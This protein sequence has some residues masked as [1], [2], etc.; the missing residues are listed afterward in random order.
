MDRKDRFMQRN[1]KEAGARRGGKDTAFGPKFAEFRK[2]A[3]WKMNEEQYAGYTESENEFSGLIG[4]QRKD[5]SG[6]RGKN[7]K[8]LSGLNSQVSQMSNAMKGVKGTSLDNEYNKFKKGFMEVGIYDGNNRE[9]KHYLPREVVEN[10]N[11]GINKGYHGNFMPN[12][13]YN[14]DVQ[15]RGGGGKR[16]KELRQAIVDAERD[17]KV[18]FWETNGRAVGQANSQVNKAKGDYNTAMGQAANARTNISNSGKV[19]DAQAREVDQ[20]VKS[21]DTKRKQIATDYST[22]LQ[23]RRNLHKRN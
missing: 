3:G 15:T 8:A 2:D 13:A 14:I 22:A 12:G 17:V 5:I 6:A 4:K 1:R 23:G 11:E 7:K 16:G 19:L 9:S 10:M 20:A 18:K 21:R